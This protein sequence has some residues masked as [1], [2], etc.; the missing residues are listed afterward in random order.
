MIDHMIFYIHEDHHESF[1]WESAEFAASKIKHRW[2]RGERVALL[3]LLREIFTQQFLDQANQ[4]RRRGAEAIDRLQLRLPRIEH[5]AKPLESLDQRS[6]Y[7]FHVR[8]R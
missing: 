8:A 3:H 6:C 7:R 4:H 1:V 5:A 2:R